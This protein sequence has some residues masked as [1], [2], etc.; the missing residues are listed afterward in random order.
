LDLRL[1]TL[2]FSLILLVKTTAV[3]LGLVSALLISVAPLLFSQP[4]SFFRLSALRVVSLA[5]LLGLT[6]LIKATAV[7][8]RLDAAFLFRIAP[9]LFFVPALLVTRLTLLL[10]LLLILALSFDLPL[11]I[12]SLPALLVLGLSFVIAALLVCLPAL[13]IVVAAVATTFG[14]RL[15]LWLAVLLLPLCSLPLAILTILRFLSIRKPTRA[16]QSHRAES[17]RQRK[18]PKIYVFHDYLQEIG[19]RGK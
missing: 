4:A 10:K 2:L 12:F 14:L 8:L 17:R 13:L 18:A 7:L 5:L 1:T 15:R 9:L 11:L 19:L 3:F 16:R 6:F